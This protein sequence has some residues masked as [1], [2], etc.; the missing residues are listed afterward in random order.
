MPK[1]QNPKLESYLLSIS[2][3]AKITPLLAAQ[4]IQNFA[5]KKFNLK[6]AKTKINQSAVS[7]NS[8]NGFFELENG[9][10][11]FFK[12]HAEENETETVSEY[13]R[14]EI[15]EKNGFP[16]ITPIFQ[17]TQPG[18][19]FLIY[20]KISAPTFFDV[21]E[22]MDAKFLTTKK[23]NEDQKQK[24]L[25]A[26][27]ELC[28]K[29]FEIAKKT[30]H[31]ENSEKINSASI[32]Q[33][34]YRRLTSIDT[35]PRLDLFYTNKK[36]QLPNGNSLPFEELAK[37]KWKINGREYQE[38]ITEII[39]SAKKIL[40]PKSQK[41]WS[42]ITAHGDDHNG[43][44]FYFENEKPNLKYFDPAFAGEN[45][46]ALLAFIKTTFHDV[47]AHPFW[48]YDSKKIEN[49][50]E[51]NFEITKQ[52]IS[53]QHN[54]ELQN[55]APIRLEILKI[56]LEKLWQPL[57]IELQK[58]TLQTSEKLM[59]IEKTPQMSKGFIKKALFCCPFLV[60]NLIDPN[61]FS[62]KVSLF[63]LSR[64]VEMGT[65]S[66]DDFLNKLFQNFTKN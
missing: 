66:D 19:Q 13:Y 10:E 3:L 59:P 35:T 29:C 55:V 37:F 12:F 53:V 50:L 40:N 61:N 4:K 45:I 49:K 52:T 21:L 15:L 44:K 24:I 42:V 20:P 41:N 22:K 17:S 1:I 14:A 57:F 38:S 43:N 32:W 65:F 64:A 34:F 7:L 47:F 58:L 16:V 23:Y 48:L 54:F 56:K 33:L 30:L 5:T 46:P 11:Y 26:E 9:T 27:K 8:V 51:L 2:K 62:P 18:E 36:I 6:I 60:M 39:D 25:A 63:A 31:I 28:E